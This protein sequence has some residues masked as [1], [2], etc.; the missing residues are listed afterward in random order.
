MLQALKSFEVL[1]ASMMD[2]THIASI[3]NSK[4]NY[5]DQGPLKMHKIKDARNP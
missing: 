3:V 5:Q 4:S 1:K 2:E